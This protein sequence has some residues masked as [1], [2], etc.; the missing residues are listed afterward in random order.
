MKKAIAFCIPAAF[1]FLLSAHA[2]T[3]TP[4]ALKNGRAVVRKSFSPR[5]E[6]DAHFYRVAL[7]RGQAAEIKVDSNSVA[8]SEE[9]ECGVYFR[10]FDSRGGEIFLGDDPAGINKWK[11]EIKTTGNYKIKIYM[12]C[13]EAFT[14]ADLQRKK[15]NFRYLLQA[16]AK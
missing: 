5:R 1:C 13:L 8:L 14:T 11:G 2:Q 7:R 4:L 9:N 16:S 12:S 10:L 6:S 3:A 15:P